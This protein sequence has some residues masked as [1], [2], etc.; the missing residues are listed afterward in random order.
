MHAGE[1]TNDDCLRNYCLVSSDSVDNRKCAELCTSRLC[2]LSAVS[3][4][5]VAYLNKNKCWSVGGDLATR[6]LALVKTAGEQANG[7]K[8]QQKKIKKHWF[9]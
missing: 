1:S 7:R 5:P 8:M 4:W 9:Q 6:T 3:H 2:K